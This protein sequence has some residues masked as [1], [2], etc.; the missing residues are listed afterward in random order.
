M[1]QPGK[2]VS[3][4]PEG[5]QDRYDPFPNSWVPQEND[6]CHHAQNTGN[7]G[8]NRGKTRIALRFNVEDNITGSGDHSNYA[9]DD[10]NAGEHASGF[11]QGK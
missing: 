4:K 5:K 2:A 11:E 1:S 10:S 7:Q 8:N 9:V 3:D 6:A